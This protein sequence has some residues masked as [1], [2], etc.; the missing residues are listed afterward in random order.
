MP[1]LATGRAMAQQRQPIGE[2]QPGR[3]QVDCNPFDKAAP[4][5]GAGH[6]AI[7]PGAEGEQNLFSAEHVFDLGP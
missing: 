4:C 5:F 2:K 3:A 7:R 6:A 1:G